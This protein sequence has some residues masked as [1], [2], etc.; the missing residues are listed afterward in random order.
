MVLRYKKPD[1]PRKFRT[2]FMP[3]VPILAIVF[4]AFFMIN[5]GGV[6]WLRFLIWLGIG[7]VIYFLYGYRHSNLN[8]S[9]EDSGKKAG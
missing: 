4:C 1:L 2:P 8:Q 3:V 6:T 5:L 7:L 9:Q